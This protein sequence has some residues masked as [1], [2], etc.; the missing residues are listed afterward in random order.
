MVIESFSRKRDL[1]GLKEPAVSGHALW[2]I[3]K[4]IYLELI[5]DK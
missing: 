3:P 2:Q 1:S 4:V 5:L